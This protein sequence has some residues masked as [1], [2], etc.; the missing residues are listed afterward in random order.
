MSL[1]NKKEKHEN[2]PC[3]CTG[4]FYAIVIRTAI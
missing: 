1:G 4:R 2:S 3:S